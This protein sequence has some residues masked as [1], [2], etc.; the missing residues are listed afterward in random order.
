EFKYGDTNDPEKRRDNLSDAKRT[1]EKMFGM[2][3]S[4]KSKPGPLME[5]SRALYDS[6]AKELG[7][8][9]L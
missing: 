1:L 3:K 4:S 8:F 7:D 6:F 9:D 2:G 5:K